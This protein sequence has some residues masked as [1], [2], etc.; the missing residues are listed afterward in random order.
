MKHR[1]LAYLCVIAVIL[2]CFCACGSGLRYERWKDSH[3]A[4]GDGE[5]Q[6]LRGGDGELSLHNC[7]VNT[8]VLYHVQSYKTIGDKVYFYGK[9]PTDYRSDYDMFLILEPETNTVQMVIDDVAVPS[10][11][12][13]D[14]KRFVSYFLPEK[15]V[16]ILL[17]TQ[18]SDEDRNTLFSLCNKMFHAQRAIHYAQEHVDLLVSAAEEARC[19]AENSNTTI[20]LPNNATSVR[21]SPYSDRENGIV[22]ESATLSALFADGVIELIQLRENSVEFCFGGTGIG[23]NTTYYELVYTESGALEDIFWY[24]SRM[25]YTEEQGGFRGTLPGSDNTVYY[26]RITDNLYYFEAHF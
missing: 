14:T 3:A 13:E 24:D 23:S 17:F 15:P 9:T 2:S 16:A 1:R 18:I 25:T 10:E 8:S 6:L 4:Y 5:Y 11:E 26:Y 7:D 19:T 12:I 22:H 21:Y 20:I